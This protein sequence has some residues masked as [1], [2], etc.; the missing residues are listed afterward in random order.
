MVSVNM[1]CILEILFIYFLSS[2][3]LNFE[4]SEKNDGS[5]S[6]MTFWRGFEVFSP[7]I[8]R[9]SGTELERGWG[10]G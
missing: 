6:E 3:D 5:S 4:L 2:G 7:I 8:L 10:G 1:F 9:A